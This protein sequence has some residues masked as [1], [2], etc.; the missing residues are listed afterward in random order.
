M[1][2]WPTQP[3][4]QESARAFAAMP[5]LAWRKAPPL[6][7]SCTDMPRRMVLCGPLICERHKR[8]SLTENYSP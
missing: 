8:I 7:R 1:F 4:K 5:L 2:A 6:H 3:G